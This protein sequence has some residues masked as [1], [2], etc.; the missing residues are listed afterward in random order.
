MKKPKVKAKPSDT[1][2]LVSPN[3]NTRLT[4]TSGGGKRVY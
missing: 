1:T 2:L 4:R 3:N